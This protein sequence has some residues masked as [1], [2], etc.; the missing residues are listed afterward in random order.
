MRTLFTT[1]AFAAL[2]ISAPIGAHA[3]GLCKLM[4]VRL[5]AQARAVGAEDVELWRALPHDDKAGYM[6][7]QRDLD[8]VKAKE[9]YVAQSIAG[10]IIACADDLDFNTLSHLQRLQEA[11]R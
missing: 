10:A 5:D 8:R 9:R 6:P 1:A 2:M 11:L 4:A 3:D 7:A